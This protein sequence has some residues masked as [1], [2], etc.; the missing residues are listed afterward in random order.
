MEG[1]HDGFSAAEEG[2]DA[3]ERKVDDASA[4][5]EEWQQL[6]GTEELE[7]EPEFTEEKPFASGAFGVVHKARCVSSLPS[8]VARALSDYGP[9]GTKERR[10]W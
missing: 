5:M 9:T 4:A 8:L 1:I 2:R 10:W 3:L 6:K 7:I